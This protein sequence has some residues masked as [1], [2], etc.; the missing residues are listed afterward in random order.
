MLGALRKHLRYDARGL[1]T[2]DTPAP[3]WFAIGAPWLVFCL[4]ALAPLAVA[5][6]V[7]LA[8]AGR[9]RPQRLLVWTRIYAASAVIGFL[10]ALTGVYLLYVVINAP[11]VTPFGAR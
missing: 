1:E 3:R 11:I 8:L 5:A 2:L 9:R 10:W 6:P 4:F 7:V